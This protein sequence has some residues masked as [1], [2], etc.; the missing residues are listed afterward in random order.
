MSG[1]SRFQRKK[2]NDS[3]TTVQTSS[4][5]IHIP[6]MIAGKIYNIIPGLHP[7][8]QVLS[9]SHLY[10]TLDQLFHSHEQCHYPQNSEQPENCKESS[11][12]RIGWDLRFKIQN[13]KTSNSSTKASI[14]EK[15]EEKNIYMQ[16]WSVLLPVICSVFRVTKLLSFKLS[17]ID[18]ACQWYSVRVVRPLLNL[19]CWFHG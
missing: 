10:Q 5:D 19:N 15:R 1:T 16:T 6:S 2:I 17:I 3:N 4:S 14:I 7:R 8:K 9:W 13:S 11:I 18:D 12:I